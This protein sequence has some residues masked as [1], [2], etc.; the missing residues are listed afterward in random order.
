VLA[1]L[2]LFLL[3]CCLC[4]NMTTLFTPDTSGYSIYDYGY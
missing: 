3:S 2:L 4:N 1:M